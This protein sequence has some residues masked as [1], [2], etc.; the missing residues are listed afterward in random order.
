LIGQGQTYSRT[1]TEP[2]RYAYFC[3]PHP[4]MTGEVVVAAPADEGGDGGAPT[5]TP[6]D[7]TPNTATE[8]AP[9]DDSPASLLLLVGAAAGL[10]AGFS[11]SRRA[12]TR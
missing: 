12:A 9:T 7:T 5:P 2:G 10:V 4:S 8:T 6:S 11:V 3:D 1:F